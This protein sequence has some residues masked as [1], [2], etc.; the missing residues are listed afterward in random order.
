MLEREWAGRPGEP[1]GRERRHL[2]T[3]AGAVERSRTYRVAAAKAQEAIL[4]LERC[5]FHIGYSVSTRDPAPL[6]SSFSGRADAAFMAAVSAFQTHH[7]SGA[8]R[9]YN[10]E[11]HRF[12]PLR[13]QSLASSPKIGVL[14]QRTIRAIVEVWRGILASGAG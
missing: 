12:S 7:F 6:P 5:L 13:S 9:A 2:D 11:S 10:H 1:G 4:L 8:R 14:D 3:G